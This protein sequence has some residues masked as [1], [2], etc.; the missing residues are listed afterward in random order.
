[1]DFNLY[2]Q[3]LDINDTSKLKDKES[4][5]F[6]KDPQTLRN[7]SFAGEENITND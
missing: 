4:I 6:N 2:L 7:W 1:M 3:K 5:E